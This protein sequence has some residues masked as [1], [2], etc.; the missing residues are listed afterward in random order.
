MRAEERTQG[1][2]HCAHYVAM[3]MRQ[4]VGNRHAAELLWGSLAETYVEGGCEVHIHFRA[5][6][7]NGGV[8]GD[9]C[10][11]FDR[12]K[13]WLDF[14][15]S[16]AFDPE[17][18]RSGSEKRDVR[19]TVLVLDGKLVE[20][21]K[22]VVGGVVPSTVRLQPLYCCLGAWGNAPKHAIE[23]ARILLEEVRKRGIALNR[24]RCCWTLARPCERWRV[25]R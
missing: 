11:V 16:K 8:A 20:L 18:Y 21:P 17:G 12:S 9:W 22:G 1:R 24:F 15:G 10:A 4:P 23:F 19:Q 2:Q 13:D 6:F 7:V 5:G 14:I 3:D 25:Q